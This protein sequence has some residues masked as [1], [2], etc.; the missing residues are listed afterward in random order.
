M[1]S[2]QGYYNWVWRLL[3][4]IYSMYWE[5][6]C[7]SWTMKNYIN[8]FKKAKRLVITY[9]CIYVCICEKGWHCQLL[10]WL[11]GLKKK[12]NLAQMKWLQRYTHKAQY[13]SI[14]WSKCARKQIKCRVIVSNATLKIQC[15]ENQ[16]KSH[17]N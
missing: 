3:C 17:N 10:G 16:E 11:V 6:K 13:P 2:L 15:P 9:I 5:N 14:N 1:Y 7:I 4:V 8:V 12:C